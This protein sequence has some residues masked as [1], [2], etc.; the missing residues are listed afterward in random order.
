MSLSVKHSRNIP[1]HSQFCGQ[2]PSLTLD[3]AKKNI[4]CFK[5]DHHHIPPFQQQTSSVST[6]L[7]TTPQ[8]LPFFHHSPVL[9]HRK[10]TY[11]HGGTSNAS[12]LP[13]HAIADASAPGIKCNGPRLKRYRCKRGEAAPDAKRK[14]SRDP[15]R[16]WN[17]GFEVSQLPSGGYMVNGCKWPVGFDGLLSMRILRML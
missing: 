12:Q 8:Y 6:T 15:K 13:R 1:Y 16:F 7:Y 5:Q 3:T 10:V 9:A 2:Y 17:I 4:I 14:G 11:P